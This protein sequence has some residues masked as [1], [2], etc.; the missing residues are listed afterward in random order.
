MLCRRVELPR[1]S[2]A[3]R[4]QP[5]HV[6][7]QD[8]SLLLKSNYEVRSAASIMM[9]SGT[10]WALPLQECLHA[11]VEQ[12]AVLC[13]EHCVKHFGEHCI[14]QQAVFHTDAWAAYRDTHLQ[15]PAAGRARWLQKRL[16]CTAAGVTVW[17][18]A[19]APCGLL[20]QPL[21]QAGPSHGRHLRHRPWLH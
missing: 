1:T 12:V 21:P 18:R 10:L 15:V 19:G 7:P 8:S 13:L 4:L 11:W 6:A 3:S 17:P 5:V 2:K 20:G 14:G 9:S 16:I